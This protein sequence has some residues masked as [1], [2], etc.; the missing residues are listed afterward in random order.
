MS[1]VGRLTGV[2]TNWALPLP[3]RRGEPEPLPEMENLTVGTRAAWVIAELVVPESAVAR[4]ARRGRS[5]TAG[6]RLVGSLLDV[7]SRLPTVLVASRSSSSAH[8][9]LSPFVISERAGGMATWEMGG[10]L[11]KEGRRVISHTRMEGS[12]GDTLHTA[13]DDTW[14]IVLNRADSVLIFPRYLSVVECQR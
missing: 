8:S 11:K 14:I 12:L 3:S 2:G 10:K 9:K 6:G 13:A 5:A 4:V 7:D 1:S